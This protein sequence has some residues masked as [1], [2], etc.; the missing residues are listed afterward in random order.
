MIAV[1]KA[2]SKTGQLRKTTRKVTTSH[3]ACGHFP[4]CSYLPPYLT[5]FPTLCG[6]NIVAKSHNLCRSGNREDTPRACLAASSGR[7]LH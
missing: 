6:S 5:S 4:L 2:T 7:E 1:A 3:E